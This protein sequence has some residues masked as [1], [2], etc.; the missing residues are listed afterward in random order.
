[1]TERNATA[2]WGPVFL[3]WGSAILL[4]VALLVPVPAES[5]TS[6]PPNGQC[7]WIESE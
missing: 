7:V 1:M 5:D 6:R 3:V 2:Y 4:W